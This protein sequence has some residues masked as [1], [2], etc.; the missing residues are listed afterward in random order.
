MGFSAY[1]LRLPMTIAIEDVVQKIVAWRGQQVQIKALSGGLTNQNFR[2]DVG[3]QAYF[4]SI[5]G[6]ATE[7]LA[8]DRVSEYYNTSAAAAAGVGARVLFHLPELNVMVLEFIHGTTMS[9]EA[10]AVAGMP[11]RLAQ[12]LKTLHAGPRFFND[13]NMFRLT[14][15]Y[16]HIVEKRNFPIPNDYRSRMSAVRRIEAAIHKKPLASVPCSNDLVAEN[17][18]DD[19]RMLR[20]VDFEYSGNNDPCFELGS[21]GCELQ[22]SPDQFAELCRAY[23]GEM[24]RHLLA[25]MHLYSLMADFGWTLWGAIQNKIS[26]LDI[27]FWAYTMGRWERALEMLDSD[28]FS[29]WLAD[30]GRED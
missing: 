13:F 19:G 27:D 4:V 25:R 5:P 24:R 29:S 8:I 10:M 16:L 26:K 2:L 1:R 12:T 21:A 7:L 14:E 11:E 9:I 23:F 28:D 20:L 6:A 17:I 30:A 15:F 3:G 22:Y 18:I